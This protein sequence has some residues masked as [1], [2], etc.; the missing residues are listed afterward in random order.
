MAKVALRKVG[1]SAILVALKV[2]S[3]DFYS[4]VVLRYGQMQEGDFMKLD[5]GFKKKGI[6]R[7][8]RGQGF[9]QEIYKYNNER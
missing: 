4:L 5:F 9:Y 8:L 6:G 7:N 1:I 3:V 2:I